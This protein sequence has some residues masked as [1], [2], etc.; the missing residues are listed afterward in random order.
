MLPPTALEPLPDPTWS[1]RAKSLL[2]S[3]T[4]KGGHRGSRER[5]RGQN[6]WTLQKE[7][8]WSHYKIGARGLQDA[9]L[10]MDK[11]GVSQITAQAGTRAAAGRVSLVYVSAK[12]VTSRSTIEVLLQDWVPHGSM[13]RMNRL[14]LASPR[15]HGPSRH[16]AHPGVRQHQV[17]AAEG[18]EA[19]PEVPAPPAPAPGALP[20]ASQRVGKSGL[21]LDHDRIAF[22]GKSLQHLGDAFS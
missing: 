6:W 12:P 2:N 11:A 20:S 22:T 18:L 7:T 9:M 19:A 14:M 8:P 5:E 1:S 4:A 3:T 13:K 10:R 16:Q 15:R 21:V 17:R